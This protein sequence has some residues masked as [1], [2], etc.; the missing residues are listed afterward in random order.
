ML[1]FCSLLNWHEELQ[2]T[3]TD[4]QPHAIVSVHTDK[5][6]NELCT[7][8][9]E[10]VCSYDRNL[11]S[12]RNSQ[13]TRQDVK[14]ILVRNDKRIISIYFIQCIRLDER[15]KNHFKKLRHAEPSQICHYIL[16]KPEIQFYITC[17]MHFLK[18]INLGNHS[19]LSNAEVQ[20]VH[21]LEC[22]G[23]FGGE[24]E[25]GRTYRKIYRYA[26]LNS[27]FTQ[28]VDHLISTSCPNLGYILKHRRVTRRVQASH[29]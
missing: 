8:A 6:I 13:D 25:E 27:Y 7:V 26:F 4:K 9:F 3:T 28:L 20:S 12:G 19:P 24:M 17:S 15:S 23:N 21:F 10:T 1:L 22:Q 14:M 11:V 18:I 16:L 29:R 5:Q 2:L